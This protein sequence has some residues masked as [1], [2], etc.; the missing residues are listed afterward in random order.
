MDLAA[1]AAVVGADRRCEPGHVRPAWH[2][3]A[4]G[5]ARQRRTAAAKI[6]LWETLRW[7]GLIQYLRSFYYQRENY[8]FYKKILLGK[9]SEAFRKQFTEYLFR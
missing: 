5:R 8:S 1:E 9:L 4:G 7:I 6:L 2:G 3:L